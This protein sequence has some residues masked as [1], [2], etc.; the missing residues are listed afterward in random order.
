MVNENIKTIS[1][2]NIALGGVGKTPHT[3]LLAEEFIKKG[4]KV[5][6]LSLGY[7]GKLG[8][9]INVI[10]DGNGNLLHHP[11]MAADEPYMMARNLPQAVVIT[12]KKREESL[13]LA[14]DSYGATVAILDDAYQYKKLKRDVNILLLDY[15]R[16]ISTGFPFPFGYLREFPVSINRADIIIFTRAVNN[17]IPESV[18]SF[19]DKQS[20]YYSNT[21]LNKV[22]IKNEI[23]DLKYLKGAV[24]C[25]YSAIANNDIFYKT[26]Q[27]AGLN[28]VFFAGFS[29]HKRI[30]EKSI[31]GII[32]QGK[33]N[34]ADLFLTTE[35]DFIKLPQEYQNA[36]GYL[37][38]EIEIHNKD[39]FI[40]E[41]ITLASK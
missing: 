8:Y 7:K 2:G 13:S 15:K 14:R 18:K 16:P 1:I 30:L 27:R 9:K 32:S 12:G 20:I 26:L 4:E 36:F 34:G 37:K 28:I 10:S 6:I 19:I 24:V 31:N 35:K 17:N 3:Q 25:A 5:A 33:I 39:N 29:D 22:V 41:I 38:M 11:P 40:N 23:V 21:V